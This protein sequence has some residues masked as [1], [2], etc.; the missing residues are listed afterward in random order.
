MAQKVQPIS[1][2]NSITAL[3]S[4]YLDYVV[5]DE[6]TIEEVRFWFPSG[7]NNA[8]HVW[9]QIIQSGSQAPT[10][11]IIFAPGT[12]N[13]MMGDNLYLQY[14]CSRPLDKYDV[15]RVNYVSVDNTNTLTLSV[16][17]VVDYYNG[18]S[19]VV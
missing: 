10:D 11:I 15:I 19:R 9:A 8:L 17:V 2:R 3:G 7:Q 12:L 13:Y 18:Q 5:P 14:P 4:G 1:F 16:D 6:G